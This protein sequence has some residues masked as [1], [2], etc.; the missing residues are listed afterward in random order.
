MTHHEYRAGDAAY[1][2]WME[3]SAPLDASPE[4][5]ALSA[6]RSR[7]MEEAELRSPANSTDRSPRFC[8]T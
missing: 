8:S 6:L 2:K 7:A 4:I 3:D 5:V 1:S